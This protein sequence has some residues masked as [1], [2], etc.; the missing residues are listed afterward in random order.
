MIDL[1]K[2]FEQSNDLICTA[3]FE[4]QFVDLNPAWSKILGYSIDELQY[5]PFLDFVYQED[6]IR[7]SEEASLLLQ[8][9]EETVNFQ[10]RYLSKSG[11]P[12]WLEWNAVVDHDARMMYG[13]ARE[14]TQRKKKE[15]FEAQFKD[16]LIQLASK[17]LLVDRSL[18]EFIYEF[19]VEIKELFKADDCQLWQM[20]DHRRYLLCNY[21]TESEGRQL[22]GSRISKSDCPVY[23]SSIEREAIIAVSDAQ[24]D[25]LT[26]ELRDN[27]LKPHGIQALL[28]TKVQ[29]KNDFEGIICIE[30]KQKRDWTI[31]EQNAAVAFSGILCHALIQ[32][33]LKASKAQLVESQRMAMIGTWEV[34]LNSQ[35][36]T[37]GPIT[38]EIF[39]VP[40][41]FEPD[42]EESLHFYQHEIS[43]QK[44]TSAFER[45]IQKGERF[46]EELL[47][48]N[49]HGEDV[50]IK[51][52]GIP[53]YKEG[54]C[55]RC[56]G[57]FQD[58]NERKKT[59]VENEKLS[60]VVD[61]THNGVLV[62]DVEGKIEWINQACTDM[63]GYTLAELKG[64]KPGEIFQGSKTKKEH[65]RKIREGLNSLK[66]FTQEIRNYRKDGSDYWIE[67]SITP[68]FDNKGNLN[69]FIGIQTDVT[70]RK[71]SEVTLLANEVRYKNLFNYAGDGVA[72]HDLEGN[73][74]EV[75][76]Q[77]ARIFGYTPE[78][79]THMSIY[80]LRPDT[81]GH[82]NFGDWALG[83]VAEKGLLVFE[84]TFQSKT[85]K[86]I[87]GEV[88]VKLF[89]EEN[90]I[91]QGI[92]RD[93]TERRKMESALIENELRIKSI[94]NSIPGAMMKYK[95]HQD[96][97][98]EILYLSEQVFDLWEVQGQE[99]LNNAQLLWQWV[100]EP[101][102]SELKNSL[103]HSKRHQLFWNHQWRIKTKSG[104]LKW[105][106]GRGLPVN[107]EDHSTVWDMIILDI[108]EQKASEF[109][110]VEAHNRAE[111]ILEATN[112]GT[113]EWDLSKDH[114]TFNERWAGII[115]YSLEELSPVSFNTWK[116]NTHEDDFEKANKALDNHLAG[117]SAF[118][119]AE[120]RQKHKNGHWV[121]VKAHGKVVKRDD[122]GKPMIVSGIHEDITLKKTISEALK[123]NEKK[124]KTLI[125]TID[126]IV[127]E[128]NPHTMTF[129]YI[130]EQSER[131]LGYPPGLWLDRPEVLLDMIHVDDKHQ[132]LG[133]SSDVFLESPSQE[134]EFRMRRA[135]S[136]YIWLRVYINVEIKDHTPV[137]LM[138]LMI[139]VTHQ[140]SSQTR[141]LQEQMRAE[142]ILKGTNAGTWEW[143]VQTGEVNFN[144]RW[145]EL[146]GNTLEALQPLSIKTWLDLYHPDDLEL[147]D[148]LLDLHFR[149]ETELFEFEARILHKNGQYV[150]IQER[151]R[152]IEWTADHKPLRMYGTAM[153]IN[154]RK[155]A[156]IQFE[157][158]HQ[159][160]ENI[161]EGTNAGTWDLNLSTKK[162]IFNERWAELLGYHL[163][164]LPPTDYEFWKS[165]LH[166][167]DIAVA[168]SAL[169]RHISGEEP[170]YKAEFRQKHKNGEWVWIRAHGKIVEWRDHEPKR[171]VGIH[172]D[173]TARKKAEIDLKKSEKK[174]REQANLL[175]AINA[176]LPGAV[177]QAIV[178]PKE[179]IHFEYM[180]E[181]IE[182]L[183]GIKPED[184]KTSFYN[185]FRFLH[186]DDQHTFIEKMQ[187]SIDTQLPF[188]HEYRY[189]PYEHA[190]KWGE[191]SAVI[192]ET[193]PNQKSRWCGIMMDIT[194]TK[195]AEEKFKR[196]F[197]TS[198]DG[199]MTI[200]ANG[201]IQM[202]N[203]QT[204]KL[205]GH[206]QSEIIG[207]GVEQLI[208]SATNRSIEKH[209]KKFIPTPDERTVGKMVTDILAKQ[210]NGTE[211]PIE[212]S[213][214]PFQDGDHINTIASVRDISQRKKAEAQLKELT[215]QLSLAVQTAKIGIWTLDTSS[216]TTE[217][218][219][220]L[221]NLYGITK[222]ELSENPKQ[223]VKYIHPD[224]FT[225]VKQTFRKLLKGKNVPGL[226]FKILTRQ[227][228]LKHCYCNALTVKDPKGGTVKIMGT[229]L[230]VTDLVVREQE[231]SA[232]L[233]QKNSLFR[234]LHHRIK[235]NLQLVSSILY[236][237]S[238]SSEHIELTRFAKETSSRIK[239]ISD[240]HN[241][242][243]RLEEVDELYT[244]EY[245]KGLVKSIVRTHTLD[246]SLYDLS[247]TI[248]NH[249]LHVDKVLSIGLL[250]NEIVSNS[251]KYAYPKEKGG[252]I[253]V[254]FK[255][256]GTSYYL[257]VG[258]K[259]VGL[260]DTQKT[261][262][263]S[264]GTQLIDIMTRQLSGELKIHNK[265][266][267]KYAITFEDE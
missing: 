225:I 256:K 111:N 86:V 75:N 198:P 192:V 185:V 236:L 163:K 74:I 226:R 188:K 102:L 261:K 81:S 213:L 238:S 134:I 214:S 47:I 235:N 144:E 150:W 16:K 70:E 10:N 2:L 194:E 155:R 55:V 211:I 252:P 187:Y 132:I 36:V 4:G 204:A 41:H 101:D 212:I 128:A 68:V 14:I 151:G 166:P 71:L 223:W 57:L 77:F 56:Y 124:F 18:D 46:D 203:S 19:I 137:K 250:I 53:E 43:Q 139:D 23:V 263:N 28:D 159:R 208:I 267:V 233:D 107:Q 179:G 195:H 258:D 24:S 17:A 80:D 59:Q 173:I 115:G 227:G 164:D 50:W 49:Y 177:F 32:H 264:L 175:G 170:F 183:V 98:E 146:S 178:S 234:E 171:I 172:Q 87:I 116:D 138:G 207:Q 26:I 35:K 97:E 64:K 248:E 219:D 76:Q 147:N 209:R 7:T 88:V 244:E 109:K 121:W 143:N 62:T 125:N 12:I 78:E 222:T 216:G 58:I 197:E 89:G 61:Q 239:S 117:K 266:G 217:W 220:E 82:E 230:E 3:N 206:S 83:Q 126:G 108:T 180:S 90:N 224:D 67:L 63:S 1:H 243:L 110:L 221:L 42:F 73:F 6:Q 39:A 65:V 127:W 158:E 201:I 120:F 255:K 112:A 21:A 190:E 38:R 142:N 186:P 100:V 20:C 148:Q 104:Q 152:V 182:Q 113:W 79:M 181:G 193:L 123:A 156:E 237:K 52:I 9:K 130:S 189:I 91:I 92:F 245:I 99:A 13:V 140:K 136:E 93:V 262:T 154:D 44:I 210:K 168:E 218:N 160:A 169:L 106:N 105:L 162:T 66:P 95:L 199:L 8:G 253:T 141:L 34:D 259:G 114:N 11:E 247:L 265:K 96:Q 51:T 5:Q 33:E 260:Q 85:G 254:M 145:A 176:S 205:F 202:A 135:D 242:L 25:P 94:A 69:Q 40:D 167:D 119:Q 45:C 27:Y 54:K 191:I 200:D 122:E 103:A 29:A 153:D 174:Y 251:L 196:L 240:I 257:E 31:E 165:T 184:A 22:V 149:G 241:Q 30:S 231:L 249:K 161:I 60:F 246:S 215:N 133:L 118:Y 84:N 232:A 48:T 72:I 131:I 15:V 37:W 229:N 129:T 157:E 228:E